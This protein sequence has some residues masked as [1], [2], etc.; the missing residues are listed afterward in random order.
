MMKELVG[1]EI[2]MLKEIGERLNEIEFQRK[3][4]EVVSFTS[5]DSGKVDISV[6]NLILLRSAWRNTTCLFLTSTLSVG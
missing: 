5:V 4:G 1:Y 6:N 2:R 3:Q